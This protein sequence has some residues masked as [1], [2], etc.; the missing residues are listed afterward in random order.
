MHSHSG[1]WERA[2]S[3]IGITTHNMITK[4]Y[5]SI[6]LDSVQFELYDYI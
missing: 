1:E 4:E 3:D 5:Y 2:K 6:Y